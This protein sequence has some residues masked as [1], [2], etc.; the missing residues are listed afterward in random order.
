V[1]AVMGAVQLVLAVRE[2]ELWS[3]RACA[4]G[5]GGGL[6][7]EGFGG[8]QAKQGELDWLGCE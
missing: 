2:T 3:C 7:C 4:A 1:R 8:G 6:G 5:R